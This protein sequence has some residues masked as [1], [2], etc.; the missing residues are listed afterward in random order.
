[1]FKRLVLLFTKTVH[2]RRGGLGRDLYEL[3]FKYKRANRGVPS[4]MQLK[5]FFFHEFKQAGRLTH[6]S[7]SLLGW[8]IRPQAGRLSLSVIGNQ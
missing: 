8:S 3:V 1:M 2:I 6:S 5:D 7:S 4:E